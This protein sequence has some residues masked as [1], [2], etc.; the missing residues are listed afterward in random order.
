[1]TIWELRE[2]VKQAHAY[3]R[4]CF[5]VCT[6]GKGVTRKSRRFCNRCQADGILARLRRELDAMYKIQ[7][8]L[9]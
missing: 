4:K 5:C 7:K 2:E 3:V 6:K 9:L 1:M 8:A